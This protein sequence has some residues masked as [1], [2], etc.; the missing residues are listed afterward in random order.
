MTENFSDLKIVLTNTFSQLAINTGVWA[1][2]NPSNKEY[3]KKLEKK[4]KAVVRLIEQ[5]KKIYLIKDMLL[6]CALGSFVCSFIAGQ[7][8]ADLMGWFS[9]RDAT[10]DVH[11]NV[12]I[13]LFNVFFNSGI[14]HKCEFA[15]SPSK[16][17]SDEFYVDFTR[18]PDYITGTLADYDHLNDAISK[19]KFDSML[20]GFFA[21][22]ELNNFVFNL[23]FRSDGSMSCNRLTFHK[24]T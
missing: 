16:S 19:D 14:T 3:F 24:K 4:F 12:S 11:D 2:K 6:I 10:N 7:T 21:G 13:D 1:E 20:G 23:D 17:S 18:I 9:D 8:K 5:G 15:V 22:N